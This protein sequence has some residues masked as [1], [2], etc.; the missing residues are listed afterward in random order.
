MLVGHAADAGAKEE[1]S[2]QAES[3]HRR[4]HPSATA[5]VLPSAAS[6]RRLS[7]PPLSAASSASSVFHF[8]SS[9]FLSHTFL[10]Q[11]FNL[12]LIVHVDL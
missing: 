9:T 7:P 12:L 5:L 2:Q 3:A 6:L 10:Q 11:D 4:P 8:S 1:A